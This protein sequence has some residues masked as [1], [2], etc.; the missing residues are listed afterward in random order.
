MDKHTH[1]APVLFLIVFLSLFS[2]A[3]AQ[4]PG[5]VI[6]RCTPSS[7]SAYSDLECA[8]FRLGVAEDLDPKRVRA[9]FARD[10]SRIAVRLGSSRSVTN[11]VNSGRQFLNIVVPG[12]IAA[13]RWRLVI[14]VDQRSS[15]PVMIEIGE[16]TPPMLESVMPQTV[17]HGEFI[18]LS[19]G[20]LHVN[21]EVEIT[22][23]L[24]RVRRFISWAS[25]GSI[26][27]NVPRDLPEGKASVRIGLAGKNSFSQ[28]LTF[29]VTT[30][31]IALTLWE[32]M[33]KVAPGQWTDLVVTSLNPLE[34]A[35]RAEVEFRQGEHVAIE[36]TL[37]PGSLH[38]RVP[39]PLKPGS[40]ELRTRTVRQALVSEWSKSIVYQIAERPIAPMVSAIEMGDKGSPVFL[41]E[42]PD[43][44]TKFE[45]EPG[46]DL[47]LRGNFP[48]ATPNQLLI[49]FQSSSDQFSLTPTE[50]EREGLLIRLPGD[51]KQG[52][53][54]L[55]I[56]DLESGIIATI[57]ITMHV[58]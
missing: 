2:T 25:G 50:G 5:P 27:F 14:E 4:N 28:P 33:T 13:G 19:G 31:P 29:V 18:W 11:D 36:Q 58:K 38:V 30:N 24:G 9:V 49:T 54:K 12:E 3:S 41:W 15:N 17:T 16:W 7:A 34:G 56:S 55:L 6:E 26:G 20:N 45:V 40:V 37:K 46:Y 39:A 51:L 32:Q 57:P 10:D 48:V 21:D 44:P 22:D 8:G 52:D 23:A 35:D 42:G 43:R 1:L 53:W 47:T